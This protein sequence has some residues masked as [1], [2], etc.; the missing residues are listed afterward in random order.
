MTRRR[1][2]WLA[3]ALC[4]MDVVVV[5]WLVSFGAEGPGRWSS[6]AGAL[7]VLAFATTGALVA[8]RRPDNPVGWLLCTSGLAFAVGGVCEEIS[9]YAAREQRPDLVAA[10]VAAWVGTYVWML[11]V[12][13]AATLLLLLFPDGRLPSPRWRPVAWLAGGSLAIT[14]IGLA[15]APGPIADT[16]YLNP[17]GVPG[18]ETVLAAAV[19]GGLALLGVSILASCASLVARFRTAPREQRQQLKWIAYSL[20][21]VLLWLAASTLVD[22]TQSGETAIEVANTLTATG[23]TVLPVA[24]GIAMLRHRLYT[25]T[26]SSTAR[27]CTERSR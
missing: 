27:S 5:A 25:S 16:P 3:W 26:S 1:A 21:L 7:F 4:A 6:A 10:P 11:G 24:I 13:P 14:V 15:L 22:S 23:L 8:S 2:G 12:G 9:G 17:L 18:G 19:A 20:P